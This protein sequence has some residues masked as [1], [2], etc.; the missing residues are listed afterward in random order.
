MSSFRKLYRSSHNRILAG[1]CGGLGE[2]FN[3]DPTLVRLI[4]VVFTLLYGV[5]LLAYLVAWIVIP[6][7][8]Y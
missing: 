7:S 6:E 4:W 3:V 1:V 5:G 2:Y 8:R